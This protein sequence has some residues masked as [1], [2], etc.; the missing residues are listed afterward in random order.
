MLK[1]IYQSNKIL[2]KN[3]C[4]KLVCAK[5]KIYK[6]ICINKTLMIS[7]FVIIV[8]DSQN[9]N[10]TSRSFSQFGLMVNVLS[11]VRALSG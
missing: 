4:I 11:S 5:R 1:Y 2:L 9:Y 10:S 8:I 7:S 6:L 3:E